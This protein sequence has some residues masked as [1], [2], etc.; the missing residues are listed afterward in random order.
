MYYYFGLKKRE[1]KFV[2]KECIFL[3]VWF[4]VVGFDVY[5]DCGIRL[6]VIDGVLELVLFIDILVLMKC[7]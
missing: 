2:L 4:V 3:Y 7:E 6:C 1:L 5:D